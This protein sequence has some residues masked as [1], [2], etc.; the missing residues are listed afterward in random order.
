MKGSWHSL[1]CNQEEGEEENRFHVGGYEAGWILTNL[2]AIVSFM[3]LVRE[4]H[5]QVKPNSEGSLPI[6]LPLF[7]YHGKKSMFIG[8]SGVRAPAQ[9]SGHYTRNYFLSLSSS[10][11]AFCTEQGWSLIG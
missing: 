3:D 10:L 9:Q 2:R 8:P 11:W 7:I 4:I 1:G 6:Y 5:R